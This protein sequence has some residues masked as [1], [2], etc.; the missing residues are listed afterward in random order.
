LRS[1]PVC[2]RKDEAVDNGRPY[3]VL[4]KREGLATVSLLSAIG[5]LEDIPSASALWQY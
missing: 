3:A 5:S 2:K 4:G 1:N